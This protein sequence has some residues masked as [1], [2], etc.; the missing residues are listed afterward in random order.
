MKQKYVVVKR[1]DAPEV[2]IREYTELEKDEFAFI[3]EERY[4]LDELKT[5]AKEDIKKVANHLR[6]PNMYPKMEYAE[7][8]AQAVISLIS[9]ENEAITTEVVFNDAEVFKSKESIVNERLR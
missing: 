2:L 6:R 8:I 7:K 5:G 4:N 1:D 3:C 9:P